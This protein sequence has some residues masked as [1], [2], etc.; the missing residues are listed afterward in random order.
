MFF[1]SCLLFTFADATADVNGHMSAHVI[2]VLWD[3]SKETS[4]MTDNS[5]NKLEM[6]HRRYTSTLQY[7]TM[8]HTMPGISCVSRA[9]YS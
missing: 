6:M 1:V 4:F 2:A 8:L 7:I 9:M 3:R 5:L